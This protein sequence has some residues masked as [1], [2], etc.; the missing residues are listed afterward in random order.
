MQRCG[1]V[2]AGVLGAGECDFPGGGEFS[3]SY[4][5]QTEAY[6]EAQ[7]MQEGSGAYEIWWLQKGHI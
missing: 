1:D 3:A 5:H 2:A 4:P 7:Q 6:T